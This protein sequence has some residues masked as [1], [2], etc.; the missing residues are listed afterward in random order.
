[1]KARKLDIV[2]AVLFFAKLY[3]LENNYE[4]LKNQYTLPEIVQMIVYKMFL[5]K[6][7][8][9]GC[10]DEEYNQYKIILEYS[11]ELDKNGCISFESII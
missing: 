9:Y 8:S 6:F 10:P 2:N 11:T 4:N 1:M 3:G 7:S 5:M